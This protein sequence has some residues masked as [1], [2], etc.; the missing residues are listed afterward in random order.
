MQNNTMRRLARYMKET[1]KN[2]LGALTLVGAGMVPYMLDGDAT[3]LAF[4]SVFA[5]GLFFTKKNCVM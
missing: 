3:F 5:I 4:V 1:Y 2:K